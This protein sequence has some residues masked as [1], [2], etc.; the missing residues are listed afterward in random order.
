MKIW[1]EQNE[2]SNLNILVCCVLLVSCLAPNAFALDE[3]PF[4]EQDET[5][6]TY[7]SDGNFIEAPVEYSPISDY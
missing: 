4:I 5:A 1:R 7:D 6:T 3:Q 2:K